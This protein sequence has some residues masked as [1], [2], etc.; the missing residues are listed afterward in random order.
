M[1]ASFLQLA[2]NLSQ[3]MVSEFLNNIEY[4]VRYVPKYDVS[5]NLLLHHAIG[6][7]T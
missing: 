5:P 3:K 7:V 1:I 6:L 2:P 4:D